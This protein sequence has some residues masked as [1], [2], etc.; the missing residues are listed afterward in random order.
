[1]ILPSP[2]LSQDR[3]TAWPDGT[4]IHDRYS[5]LRGLNAAATRFPQVGQVQVFEV[6]DLEDDDRPKVLKLLIR[7]QSTRLDRLYR[8]AEV[9]MRGPQ[10]P[11]I[12]KAAVDGFFCWRPIDSR[13]PFQG[14]V[15]E[16]I[17]GESLE[18]YLDRQ[19]A[20]D[21]ME[22]IRWWV[23][24]SSLLHNLHQAGWVHGDVKPANLIRRPQGDLAL[25]DF[26]A[27]MAVGD[28]AAA[29]CGSAGYIAPEQRER[30]PVGPASDWFSL[31]R[32]I[33]HWLTG[34]HPLDLMAQSVD[35]D[36]DWRWAVPG[37][38]DSI[39]DAIDILMAPNPSD[40]RIMP[41]GT[42]ATSL[43]P[44]AQRL[45]RPPV[46]AT[47]PRQFPEFPRAA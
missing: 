43:L 41:A 39:A 46:V 7:Q 17:A 15:M 31:G 42:T 33:V 14:L 40:R 9:L 45:A 28:R 18:A 11:Q 20:I 21:P 37:L 27:A 29:A 3:K 32:T 36:F 24:L 26:D 35:S 23:Q 47:P 25:V 30:E 2:V 8:E 1:M 5:I 34:Q 44:L 16:A 12:P 38:P 10:H 13:W 19:G 22:A 4:L 6:V